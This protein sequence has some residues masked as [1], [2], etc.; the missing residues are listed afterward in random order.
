MF[1]LLKIHNCDL[2]TKNSANDK[3]DDYGR[4]CFKLGRKIPINVL[5]PDDCPLPK[6]LEEADEL[7]HNISSDEIT[8]QACDGKKVTVIHKCDDCGCPIDVSN[9]RDR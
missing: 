8:C 9:W 7:S 3:F 1:R 2:C 6:V 4:Y 5:I